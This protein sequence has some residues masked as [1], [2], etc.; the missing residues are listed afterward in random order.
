MQPKPSARTDAPLWLERLLPAGEPAPI[1]EIVLDLGLWNHT[2]SPSRRPRVMLTVISSADGRATLAERAGPL[3]DTAGRELFD[4]LRDTVDAVLVGASTTRVAILT[5]SAASLHDMPAHVELVRSGH[6][7][8]VDLPGTLTE[9][10]ERLGV[11]S[12]L[13]EVG[14]QLAS[15]LLHAGLVDELFLLLS[16]TLTGGDPSTAPALR[17]LAGAE[18]APPVELELLG[19]LRSGSSLF[20]RYGVGA[21]E[22]VSR[23]TTLSSSEAR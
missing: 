11:R 12:L 22:R 6:D 4:G 3:D 7:G 13:C 8:R 2:P 15:E 17:V 1:A 10:R 23:E 21:C 16:P 14:P 18:V 5:P 9:L 19:V 20:L